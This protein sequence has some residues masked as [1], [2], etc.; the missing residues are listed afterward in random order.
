MVTLESPQ[1]L[2]AQSALANSQEFENSLR[3]ATKRPTCNQSE[4][5]TRPLPSGRGETSPLK[6][7]QGFQGRTITV[8]VWVALNGGVPLSVTVT[9]RRLVDEAW[10]PTG[11]QVKRPLESML[12]PDGGEI[13]P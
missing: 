2:G 6:P 13:S 1:G 10:R 12:A 7:A 8:K 9:T 4:S 5:D 11:L 3:P